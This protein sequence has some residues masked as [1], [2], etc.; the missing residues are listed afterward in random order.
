MQDTEIREI[1]CE[2]LACEKAHTV[3]V[4]SPEHE[5]RR[6]KKK[7]SPRSFSKRGGEREECKVMVVNLESLLIF[8]FSRVSCH[9]ATLGL[10][11]MDHSFAKKWGKPRF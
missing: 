5:R 7:Y 10:A 3:P 2:F 6:H 4:R 9:H 1:Y 8:T 11:H